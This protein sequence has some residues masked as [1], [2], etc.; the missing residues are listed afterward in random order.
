MDTNAA[1]NPYTDAE[2]DTIG[3]KANADNTDDTDTGADMDV[4]NYVEQPPVEQSSGDRGM[5]RWIG[6]DPKEATSLQV[7][8]DLIE[9]R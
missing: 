9:S 6:S 4:D 3:E 2:T 8:F 1:T 7:V 5:G